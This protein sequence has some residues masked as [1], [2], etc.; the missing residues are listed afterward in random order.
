MCGVMSTFSISHNG[1]SG[2][3][4]AQGRRRSLIFAGVVGVI[5]VI[6]VIAF[7]LYSSTYEST[8]DA[9]VD[10]HLNGITAR[11]DGDAV[12]AVKTSGGAKAISGAKK[13]GI[14]SES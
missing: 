8:D 9:E 3:S 2:G 12:W 5:V 11:I 4:T 10:G 7:W 14:P 6:G 13:R 1:D